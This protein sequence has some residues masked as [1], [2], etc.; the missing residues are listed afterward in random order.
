MHFDLTSLPV[1]RF[2]KM[3]LT[4]SGKVHTI[5]QVSTSLAATVHHNWLTGYSRLFGCSCRACILY[6]LLAWHVVYASVLCMLQSIRQLMLVQNLAAEALYKDKVTLNQLK[7]AGLHCP[8]LHALLPA[9]NLDL[10]I[11]TC[12]GDVWFPCSWFLMRVHDCSYT[13]RT[14]D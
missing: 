8:D 12:T 14:Q 10:Y 13:C 7:A 4:M 9:S 5:V 3:H 11:E 2:R 1:L 6:S